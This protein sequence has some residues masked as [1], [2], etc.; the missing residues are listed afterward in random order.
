M[1]CLRMWG[2]KIIVDRPSKTEGAGTSHLQLVR[3]RG[4]KPTIFKP[5]ILK[6]HI[7]E[8]PKNPPPPR[9]S[10]PP[11]G[12]LA[13]GRCGGGRLCAEG[14][15]RRACH[16]ALEAG[17]Q[18]R[19]ARQGTAGHG[20][21]RQGTA[22]HGRARQDTAGLGRARHGTAGHTPSHHNTTQ[23]NPSQRNAAQDDRSGAPK[24]DLPNC[25]LLPNSFFFTDI[26]IGGTP[27]RDGGQAV[28]CMYI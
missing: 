27:R 5:H 4:S 25:L 3:V 13:G 15:R 24:T 6:H 16:K 12:G 26:G 10:R 23:R 18:G 21:A 9:R 11:T 1:W 2:L 8:H 28:G 14:C 7:P 20:R 22:G 17:G 19:R